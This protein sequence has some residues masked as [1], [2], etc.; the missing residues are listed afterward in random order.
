MWGFGPVSNP[1]LSDEAAA[2]GVATD[3]GV[4][5]L[6]DDA[7]AKGVATDKGVTVLSDAA[8]SHDDT[9]NTRPGVFSR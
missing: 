5:V 8:V 9:S 2:K 4:A 1:V 7:A 6:S 3:K